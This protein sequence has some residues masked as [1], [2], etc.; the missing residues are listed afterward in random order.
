MDWLVSLSWKFLL[1][2][3]M[4]CDSCTWL[5]KNKCSG[6]EAAQENWDT[7]AALGGH[8]GEGS[9]REWGFM[10]V[11]QG[12]QGFPM[13]SLLDLRP[14]ASTKKRLLLLILPFFFFFFSFLPWRKRG[15]V[16]DL[17]LM[18]Q[19]YNFGALCQLWEIRLQIRKKK[20]SIWRHY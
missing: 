17:R 19:C 7:A 18:V 16:S 6:K 4:G 12:T 2:S 5:P 3:P 8:R 14:K 10:Q 11:L 15:L 9:S 1:S 13:K 20:K